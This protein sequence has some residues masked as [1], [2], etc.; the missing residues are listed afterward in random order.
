MSDKVEIIQ[1]PNALRA[2]VGGKFGTLDKEAIAAAESALADL[3]DQFGD[4]LSEEIQNLEAV[5]NDIKTTGPTEENMKQLYNRCHDLKGQGSTYGYPLITRIAGSVCKLMDE[6][7]MRLNAPKALIVA[8]LD[9][10][11]AIVRSQ[12]KSETHPVGVALATELEQRV[13]EHLNTL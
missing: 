2:K 8:H 9:A 4:W 6:P 1:V 5:Y 7:D 11:R 10:I 12:I 3:S 13:R